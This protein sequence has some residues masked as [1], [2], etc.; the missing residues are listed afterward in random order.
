[1]ML[2]SGTKLGRYFE[3]FARV[4]SAAKA[5]RMIDSLSKTDSDFLDLWYVIRDLQKRGRKV[6]R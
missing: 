1:M 5:K 3:R 2:E 4:K 6:R